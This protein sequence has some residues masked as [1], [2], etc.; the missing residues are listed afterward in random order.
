MR[1]IALFIFSIISGAV[2]LGV[3]YYYYT[4]ERDFSR[5]YK[6]VI[7]GFNQVQNSQ[8][9]TT[10]GVLQS[11]LFAYYNQD[12][13]AKDRQ[14]LLANLEALLQHPLL[15]QP[16]YAGVLAELKKLHEETSAYVLQVERHLMING[17]IKNSNVFLS[18][19]EEE[20]SALF[21]IDTPTRQTI[22][23]VIDRITQAKKML[24]KS[25]LDDIEQYVNYLNTQRYTSGQQQFI[26]H[27]MTHVNFII[28]QYPQYLDVFYSII[29][30]PLRDDIDKVK[31]L[32]SEQ[33]ARDTEYIN[34]LG[35]SLFILILLAII[36]NL[37]LIWM[38]R[39]ENSLLVQLKERLQY[40][41]YYDSLTRLKNRNSYERLL[42]TLEAP[43]V[44]L[45]NIAKF[46]Y[47]NDFYGT[48]TGD[49]ILKKVASMLQ[50]AAAE[51][52]AACHRVGGDEF[53]LL[54]DK[55][56]TSDIEAVARRI[57]LMFEE[58][59]F[60]LNGIA[61]Q[62]SA[63]MA[64]SDE[65]PLLETAD[66][67]LKHLR[68]T[69]SDVV[70]HYS[71]GL[72]VEAQIHA[73]IETTHQLHSAL[74]DDRIVPY[75]QPVVDLKSRRVVKYEALARLYTEDGAVLAPGTFF[76]VAYNTSLYYQITRMMIS[77]TLHYFADKP[78]RFSFNL[79]MQ[80]L[81]DD[82]IV[83]M[84][85]E[86]LEMYGRD[87]ASR[88]DIELLET[89]SFSNKERVKSFISSVKKLGCRIAIDDFG[90][91]FSNF[92]QLSE[93]DID[94]VKIDGSLIE[95]ITTN[96]QHY[97]SVKA[98]MSLLSTLGVESVAEYVQD[99][100]SACMLQEL[101]VDHGQGFYFGTPQADPLS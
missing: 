30:A 24:D 76:P 65:A 43:A 99:E 38:L 60:E 83:S 55:T 13:I 28:N 10:Y 89:E 37:S 52:D 35:T 9:R 64:I 97:K 1:L 41:L 46:K 44:L 32:F 58:E 53:A 18:V 63:I 29:N 21:G 23:K 100:E 26:N 6:E 81:E 75:Y 87:V 3:L 77:K 93:F 51:A 96:E 14:Q 80:D 56:A 40:S 49:M 85:L 91:G 61:M 66:M 31:N 95:Q 48:D 86:Q 17:A 62:I 90:S 5:S 34:N 8:E 16:H 42:T 92:T 11:A 54:F 19:Y 12:P 69:L 70:V 45:L 50:D 36:A 22:H 79:G 84:I 20:A 25:Y 72:N 2:A 57:E 33:A 47:F 88:L 98:I 27:L 82:S 59:R 78:Y 73:N 15:Q 94:V 7:A 39:H 67:A 68:G 74:F 71:P 101:G 4:V